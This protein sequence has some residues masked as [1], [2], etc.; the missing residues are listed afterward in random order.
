MQ[1]TFHGASGQH[2]KQ[3]SGLD[4][5]ALKV[6][7]HQ[8]KI[9]LDGLAFSPHVQVVGCSTRGLWSIVHLTFPC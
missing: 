3:A 6:A 1:S 9:R 2:I 4:N 5:V 7:R 8:C